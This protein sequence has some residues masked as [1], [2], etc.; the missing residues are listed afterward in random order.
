MVRAVCC[1]YDLGLKNDPT[2]LRAMLAR[3]TAPDSTTTAV[4]APRRAKRLSGAHTAANSVAMLLTMS[5][6]EVP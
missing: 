6:A 1:R 5:L 2:C 3:N 4:V